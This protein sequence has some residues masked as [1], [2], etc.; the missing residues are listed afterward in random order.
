MDKIKKIIIYILIFI[1]VAKGASVPRATEWV[2]KIYDNLKNNKT[3]SLKKKVWAYR[4][5]YMPEYVSKYNI[6]A[7]NIKNFISERDYYYLE[8]INGI[9]S[10]WINDMISIR[11]VF[12]PFK[13]HLQELYYE[14]LINEDNI[15]VIPL[16]DCPNAER[17][18]KAVFDLVRKK[19]VL[20]LNDVNKDDYICFRYSDSEY[21]LNDKIIRGNDDL[22]RGIRKF[23]KNVIAF[24]KVNSSE[25]L[26][27]EF[28]K[29]GIVLR[30]L[31]CNDGDAA[32]I[33]KALLCECD[34]NG[35]PYKEFFK[36]FAAEV[37]ISTGNYYNES[38]CEYKKIERWENIK[39]IICKIS[40]HA[41]QLEF[42]GADILITEDSFK[43]V[44]FTNTPAYPEEQMFDIKTVDFLKEK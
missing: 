29:S 44:G 4:H 3:Y 20:L 5:G 23:S 33:N 1:P 21:Y 34:E 14:I 26:K 28:K 22:I 39:D 15:S 35:V 7:D 24:E 8:P 9:Y 16:D 42:F 41:P 27:S 6:N 37:D 17:D 10:K 38:K 30:M 19:R 36:G 13:E 32:K 43:F 40:K 2:T 25:N 11:K 12:E 31:V 18:I